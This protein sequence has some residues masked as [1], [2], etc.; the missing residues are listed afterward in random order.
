MRIALPLNQM[1]A[2]VARG[3]CD[4]QIVMMF[5]ELCICGW[6]LGFLWWLF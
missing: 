4:S 3:L 5:L 6:I 1:S 2:L